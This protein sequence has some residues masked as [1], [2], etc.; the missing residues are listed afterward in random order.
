MPSEI[1]WQGPGSIEIGYWMHVNETGRG[2][3]TLATAALTD[4][5]SFQ[6]RAASSLLVACSRVREPARAKMA[7]R[8][9]ACVLTS[10]A[11]PSTFDTA[12]FDFMKHLRDRR[13]THRDLP[14]GASAGSLT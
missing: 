7:R 3:A 4:L 13:Q 10:F 9:A 6:S 12:S 1:R 2:L 5:R 14:G 11:P 8:F